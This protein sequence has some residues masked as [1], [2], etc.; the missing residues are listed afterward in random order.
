MNSSYFLNDLIVVVPM[1]DSETKLTNGDF[2]IDS[3]LEVSLYEWIEN[4][5]SL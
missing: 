2:V 3:T 5:K 1:Y 4:T